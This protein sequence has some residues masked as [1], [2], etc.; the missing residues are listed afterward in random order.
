MRILLS[1][2]IFCNIIC[3]F[4]SIW[5]I[6]HG[7]TLFVGI[8]F[9]ILSDQ[10]LGWDQFRNPCFIFIAMAVF[11]M[12]KNI[13]MYSAVINNLSSMSLIIYVVQCNR[14]LRDYVRFDVFDYIYTKYTYDKLILWVLLYA[15]VS[16]IFSFIIGKLYLLSIGKVVRF[17]FDKIAEI[18]SKVYLKLEKYI[19][20][21]S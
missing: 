4:G 6:L 19:L 21:I 9:G 2:N 14:I 5:L 3:L 12:V 10:L 8:R 18:L 17:V 1:L 20:K 16:F 7:L 11:I 15:V 13:T